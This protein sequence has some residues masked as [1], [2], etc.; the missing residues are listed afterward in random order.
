[1]IAEQPLPP[2]VFIAAAPSIGFRPDLCSMVSVEPRLVH[3]K[4]TK[5][6]KPSSCSTILVPPKPTSMIQVGPKANLGLKTE[7]DH[8]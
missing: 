2:D 1:M 5:L 8:E 7:I 6:A 4:R 3:P